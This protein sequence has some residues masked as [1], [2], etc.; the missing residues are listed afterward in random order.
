MKKENNTR[1]FPGESC[2]NRPDKAAARR[3]EATDR[4][5]KTNSLSPQQR[6]ENLD[7]KF[8][9]GLGAKKERA[10]L[11]AAI[12]NKTKPTKLASDVDTLDKKELPEEVMQEIAA[13]NEEGGGSK[14]RLKAK[15]RRA[16]DKKNQ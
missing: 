7:I 6:L 16:K 5:D 12:N 14:K 3:A 11:L 13:L 9:A 8:G 10:R 15:E 1:R 4:Q 2:R